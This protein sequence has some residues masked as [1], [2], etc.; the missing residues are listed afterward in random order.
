MKHFSNLPHLLQSYNITL[1]MHPDQQ[2][3]R[4]EVV[5]ALVEVAKKFGRDSPHLDSSFLIWT[6]T[7]ELR[8]RYENISR[9][10]QE[11][12]FSKLVEASS[13]V[14]NAYWASLENNPTAALELL[15]HLPLG[16][17]GSDR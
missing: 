1:A 12:A 5:D 10:E 2:H 11:V 7:D 15:R 14:Q 4:A 17:G 6:A 9:P 13:P 3:V 8:Q 16:E